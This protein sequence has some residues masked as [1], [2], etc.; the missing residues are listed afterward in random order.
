MP[1]QVGGALVQDGDSWEACPIG[2]LIW[3]NFVLFFFALRLCCSDVWGTQAVSR[4]T[5]SWRSTKA[6]MPKVRHRC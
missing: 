3:C 5:A 1:A 2:S 4:S 6:T